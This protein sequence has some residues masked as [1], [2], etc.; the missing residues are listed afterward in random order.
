MSAPY[1]SDTI[2]IIDDTPAGEVLAGYLTDRGSGVRVAHDGETGIRTAGEVRPAL[3]L[4]DASM[5]DRSG[6]ATCRRLKADKTTREIP[7]I[8]MIAAT[9]DAA[10][11]FRAGAADYLTKPVRREE[12]LARIT[13]HLRLQHLTR[14]LREADARLHTLIDN[15]PLEFWAL[16]ADLCYT[17]QNA[18]SR[19]HFDDVVGRRIEDIG[20]PPDVAA[21]WTEQDKRVLQGEVLRGE[22]E[23]TLAGEK[24]TYENLVAPVV[25]GEAVVGIVGVALD[26]TECKRAEEKQESAL[27][28]LRELTTIVNRS[29]AVVFLWR[30]KEGWP[31]EYVSDNVGQFGYTP[32]DFTSG[33]IPYA[34]IIHPDD[35]ERVAA[36]VARY[37]REGRD[38]FAQE[39]RICMAS[40]DVLWIDDR[41]W[42]RRDPDGAITHY[43]GIVIDITERKEAQEA[44]RQAQAEQERRVEE[45]TADLAKANRMLN[46]LSTCNQVVVRVTEEQALLQEVC[47]IIVDLGGYPLVWV[48]FAEQDAARTVRPV[49]QA[50]FED[51]YLETLDITWADTGR[52]R[53]RG[54]TGTAIRSGRPIIAGDILTDPEFAPWREEA[55]RRGYMSSI[56]LPLRGDEGVFG[57]LNIYAAA[58]D[59]FH[60]EEVHLL[61][62]LAG[63]LAFGITSLRRRAERSRAEEALR[64]SEERYRSLVE[65]LPDAVVVHRDDTI[66]YINPAAVRLF[67]GKSSETFVGSSVYRFVHPDY[68]ERVAGEVRRMHR[69]GT[70]TPLFEQKLLTLDGRTFWVDV[71]AAPI[72]YQGRPSTLVVARDITDRKRAEE[73]IREAE[74]RNAVLLG[75]IPDLMFVISR[76]GEYRDF[77]TPDVRL[78]ALPPDEIIGKNIRDAGFSPE[79]ADA[80]LQTIERTIETR[81]L[82]RLEYMLAVP[83]GTRQFEARLLALNDQE[84]LC[85][86]RDITDRKQAEENLLHHTEDLT[87]LHRQLAAANREANLYLDI[88]THDIGNTENV[89]NLYADLLIGS[90][91]G[92]TA[93]YAKKL[94]RSIRKSIE[95]LRTVATIRR[96][97]QAP[98]ELKPM[99]LNAVIRKAIEDFPGS[100]IRYDGAD[101]SVLADDLLSV[102]LDNL[103]GNAVKFGGPDVR[104]AVRAEEEDGL[105]RVTVED[106]GPGVPDEE[107]DA[108]FHRYEQQKRGVGEGLG[109]YL[110]QILV[111]R[112]GGRV[113][114]EDRACGRPEEGAAFRF[115]LRTAPGSPASAAGQ[116][117]R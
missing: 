65:L 72:H 88:L 63:D 48:G 86:V 74:H 84:V 107:K 101:Y 111:E 99:N 102:V 55:I 38:E 92:E 13:T 57:A 50:G 11:G 25:V 77:Q 116:N 95:I 46:I 28:E 8:V 21:L 60:A 108:I 69:E 109:L 115:T 73:R 15:L 14:E 78:L 27:A 49:A 62:E 24:R 106:T 37:S 117:S 18:A 76:R 47:R 94:Q 56:A 113:W 10:T 53:G 29:P 90:L 34:R 114:V 44:L 66:V 89:S 100:A 75:A 51:G 79:S 54:P 35:R 97:H 93:G 16:D 6:F 3:I 17:L 82:Q 40:G 98:S 81:E 5:P 80:I 58:P 91:E 4:L 30:A 112:Y 33:R 59:A 9:E 20:L 96:I 67:G 19:A 36:E 45:R 23:R 43:Q 2:L 39:Y 85:I 70:G 7:V 1:P 104:I 12:L 26:V 42:V 105:V 87:R 61:M 71:T 41:T 103:I 68:R 31:V 110:V 83:S 32:E 22:Y 52:G 64:E